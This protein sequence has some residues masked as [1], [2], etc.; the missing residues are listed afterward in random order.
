MHAEIVKKQAEETSTLLEKEA[1]F[2]GY[3]QKDLHDKNEVS[4]MQKLR[5]RVHIK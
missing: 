1:K 2:A 5:L 4:H 3:W